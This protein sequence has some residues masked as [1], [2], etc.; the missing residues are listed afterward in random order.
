MYTATWN[1]KVIAQSDNTVEVEGNQ[2]FPLEDVT[3]GVLSDSVLTSVCPWKGTANYYHL[4][5]DGEQNKDAAWTY[6]T[7]KDAAKEI[8][9]RVAFWRGVEVTSS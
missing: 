5:V 4:N 6:R 3:E 2:Y 9:N 8:T 1:G 7:P